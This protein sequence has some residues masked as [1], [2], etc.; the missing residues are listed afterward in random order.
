M[1]PAF[2]RRPHDAARTLLSR[3]F[4]W[5]TIYGKVRYIG[6]PAVLPVK[7]Q[8]RKV[9]LHRKEGQTAQYGLR[10]VLCCAACKTTWII[11]VTLQFSPYC[12]HSTYRPVCRPIITIVGG[13]S[14]KFHIT[15]L[16]FTFFGKTEVRN[17]YEHWH[18]G[19][20]W[21]W[22]L[23]HRPRPED[24]HSWVT[25]LLP[26]SWA[27]PHLL[28]L[29]KF[30]EGGEIYITI[31]QGDLRGLL[32][33][34]H[35]ATD[36]ASTATHGRKTPA[37][38]QRAWSLAHNIWQST[39]HRWSCCAVGKATTVQRFFV[40]EGGPDSVLWTAQCFTMRSL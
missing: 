19:R 27:T 36:I 16:L 35:G 18:H 37:L 38:G 17:F 22:P 26:W 21:P 32:L 11:Q 30:V 13:L 15:S 7:K 6:D 12:S 14:P 40:S 9:F 2:G 20:H 33:P 28:G 25:R 5:R 23:Y 24:A 34:Q 4:L 39:I 3:V 31:H 8:L 29:I 10:N 1:Q